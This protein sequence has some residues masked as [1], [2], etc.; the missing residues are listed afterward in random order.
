MGFLHRT[1]GTREEQEREVQKGIARKM[2]YWD[3]LGRDGMMSKV[4]LGAEMT[5]QQRE[6]AHSI[7]WSYRDCFGSRLSHIQGGVR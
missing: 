6:R 1:D 7:I 4:T 5:P 2:Q 3:E